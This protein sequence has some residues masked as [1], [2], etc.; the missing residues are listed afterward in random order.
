[1]SLGDKIPLKSD[2]KEWKDPRKVWISWLV[3][4]KKC[5]SQKG[6]FEY[7]LA[8]GKHYVK[9]FSQEVKS[10]PFGLN[11]PPLGTPF[12]V[13]FWPLRTLNFEKTPFFGRIWA[14][15]NLGFSRV[16]KGGLKSPLKSHF[17]EKT[18]ILKTRGCSDCTF[19][20][21]PMKYG[22]P[23]FK[24]QFRQKRGKLATKWP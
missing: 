13:L 20:A 23:P 22:I 8:V 7:D 17:F 18:T 2:K 10:P 14:S 16:K 3:V 12:L 1:M 4:D 5:V 15:S 19:Q 6:H 21:R 9:H 24:A 11:L